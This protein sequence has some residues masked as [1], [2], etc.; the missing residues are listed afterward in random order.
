MRPGFAMDV[1]NAWVVKLGLAIMADAQ[2]GGWETAVREA[3]R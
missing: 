2:G 3:E 1:G